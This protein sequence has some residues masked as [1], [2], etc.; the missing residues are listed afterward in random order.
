[1][2]ATNY[3]RHSFFASSIQNATMALF[4]QHGALR[5]SED[6]FCSFKK[7]ML[8][9]GYRKFDDVIIVAPDVSRT[10]RRTRKV[11][12]LP[13]DAHSQLYFCSLITNTMIWC[14]R[15]MPSGI[16]PSRGGIGESGPNLTQSVAAIRREI[17]PSPFLVSQCWTRCWRY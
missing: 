9:Q 12:T 5:N 1:M 13:F 15:R 7:L 14:T 11:F 8:Q 16:Q 2:G 10:R 4:I 3:G 17:P 6:Y